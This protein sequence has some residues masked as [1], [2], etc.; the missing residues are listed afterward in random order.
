[1]LEIYSLGPEKFL[2]EGITKI[3]LSFFPFTF[4]SMSAKAAT[5][6]IYRLN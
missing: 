1:M 3:I 2:F 4:Q 5:R 6:Q